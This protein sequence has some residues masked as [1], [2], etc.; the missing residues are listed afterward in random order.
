MGRVIRVD[1]GRFEHLRQT[2]GDGSWGVTPIDTRVAA[3]TVSVVEPETLSRVA[4]IVV[5]PALT[6]VASP[7]LADALLTDATAVLA[8]L[9][10]TDEETSC[11]EPSL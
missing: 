5:E 11:F 2:A 1:T 9:Q 6:V 10:V 8:E 4:M 3:V 7:M